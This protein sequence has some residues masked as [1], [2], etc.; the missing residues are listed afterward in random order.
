MSC[1]QARQLVSYSRGEVFPSSFGLQMSRVA[2]R[3]ASQA[4]KSDQRGRGQVNW[5]PFVGTTGG[6]I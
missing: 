3:S 2:E 6:W 5:T 1:D 4:V